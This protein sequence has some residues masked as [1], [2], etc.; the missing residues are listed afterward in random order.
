[1][2]VYKFTLILTLNV[3]LSLRKA[4]VEPEISHLKTKK[5][6]IALLYSI[7]PISWSHSEYL[8]LEIFKSNQYF[9]V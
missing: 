5:R 9:T 7:I 8:N 4:F 6:S 1:M 3:E 2:A